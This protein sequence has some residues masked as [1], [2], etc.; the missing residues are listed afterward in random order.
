MDHWVHGNLEQLERQGGSLT[1]NVENT[2]AA[3]SPGVNI[4]DVFVISML[5]SGVYNVNTGW[6]PSRLITYPT[7]Y[8]SIAASEWFPV[9][10][11]PPSP[12]PTPTQLWKARPAPVRPAPVGEDAPEM[13]ALPS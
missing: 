13:G 5:F 12:V 4:V 8:L 7:T 2:V 10:P 9:A 11:P 6:A 1:N 3:V